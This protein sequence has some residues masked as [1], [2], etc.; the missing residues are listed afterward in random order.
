LVLFGILAP[1]FEAVATKWANAGTLHILLKGLGVAAFY[2]AVFG[3]PPAFLIG[4][5]GW[6]AMS[7]RN[8]RGQAQ[9][10]DGTA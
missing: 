5:V 2:L 10:R 8:R 6:V 7:I 4:A 3:F 1:V 9:G